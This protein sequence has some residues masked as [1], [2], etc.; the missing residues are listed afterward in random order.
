MV[1]EWPDD[2]KK[3]PNFFNVA[4]TVAKNLSVQNS[5]END[6]WML[7]NISEAAY[8]VKNAIRPGQK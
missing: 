6:L 2:W 5:Y 4:K 7:K 3:S 1:P 8:L